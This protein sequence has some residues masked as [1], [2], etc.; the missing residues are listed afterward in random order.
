M[1]QEQADVMMGETLA[2]KYVNPI[3]E[4]L[5]EENPEKKPKLGDD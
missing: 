4:S 5:D 1:S 3:V 2:E